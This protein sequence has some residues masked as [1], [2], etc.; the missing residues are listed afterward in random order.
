MAD[1]ESPKSAPFADATESSMDIFMRLMAKTKKHETNDA[2][3]PPVARQC[4]MSDP[5]DRNHV[6]SNESGG[7]HVSDME[8]WDERRSARRV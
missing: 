6:H 8:G 3:N 7:D 2:C 5:V 4:P 1:P